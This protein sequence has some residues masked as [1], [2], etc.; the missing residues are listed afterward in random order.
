MRPRLLALDIESCREYSPSEALAMIGKMDLAEHDSV[1]GA[2]LRFI[3]EIVSAVA[4]WLVFGWVASLAAVAVTGLTGVPGD[5]KKIFIKISGKARYFLEN[6]FF[7]AGIY[8]LWYG[9]SH[10]TALA[11]LQFVAAAW[12]ALA[13]YA[14]HSIISRQRSKWL[15]GR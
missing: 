5:K 4:I 1:A 7:L 6:L 9:Q 13:M 11:S 8:S 2:V 15:L 12:L 3:L 10:S 14:L